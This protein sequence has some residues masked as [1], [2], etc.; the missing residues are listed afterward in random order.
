MVAKSSALNGNWFSVIGLLART[1]F[2]VVHPAESQET[3]HL[4]RR[5]RSQKKKE[6]ELSTSSNDAMDSPRR[7]YPGQI[8][9]YGIS[10]AIFFDFSNDTQDAKCRISLHFPSHGLGRNKCL[11]LCYSF[12]GQSDGC[13]LLRRESVPGRK[14]TDSVSV[15]L[16]RLNRTNRLSRR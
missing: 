15:H 14:L 12:V 4:E 6:R 1:V 11:L 10:Q 3:V 9:N 7:N 13:W 16:T 2:A 5:G 8:F